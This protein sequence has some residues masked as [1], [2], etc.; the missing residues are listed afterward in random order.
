MCVA[1]VYC[2]NIHLYFLSKYIF[3]KL[4]L[5]HLYCK[6]IHVPQMINA[7]F[8]YIDNTTWENKQAVCLLACV[9]AALYRITNL[10]SHHCN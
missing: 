1:G 2:F 9:F 7:K 10:Y 5:M 8:Q 3:V 6:S 4:L